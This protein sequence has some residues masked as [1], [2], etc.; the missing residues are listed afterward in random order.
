MTRD[1]PE[2]E[3]RGTAKQA[4]AEAAA[5]LIGEGMVVGLGTGSTATLFLEALASRV[6]SGLKITG[7]ATSRRTQELASR[8]AIP[9]SSL[10]SEPRLD[11]DI[12]GAD[13]IDPQLNALKGGGGA[14]LHE[15]IVAL[16]SSE[17]VIIA[18]ESK[19]V[20]QLCTTLPVP[21]EVI[22]FGWPSTVRRIEATGATVTVRGGQVS[23]YITDGGN[24]ILDVQVSRG[25]DLFECVEQLKSLT[26]VVDHGIF[27]QVAAQALIGHADGS[28]TRL[29]RPAGGADTHHVL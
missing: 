5:A 2:H 24:M 21:V 25:S 17:L 8:L 15:K 7:V 19:L 14:L 16:A 9:V 20:S 28:V 18:D 10:E 29:S 12:D 6:A 3:G 1:E 26:G 27:R 23:P 13:E 22:A 4:A 11:L